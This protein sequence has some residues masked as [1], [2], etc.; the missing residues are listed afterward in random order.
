MATNVQ[1]P[2]VA[3]SAILVEVSIT[4]Y[5][6]K[7]KD[8]QTQ[9]EVVHD[10]GAGS[11]K[12]ASVYKNLFA[13]CKELDEIAKFSARVRTSHYKYTMP[14]SYTGPAL[15]PAGLLKE[16]QTIMS[17][18]EAEFWALVK[19]FLD[20][21]DT[22][23]AAA[24]FQLGS[25][26][27]RREYPSRSSI[28]SRFGFRVAYTPVPTSGDF[29]LDIEKEIQQDLVA[30]C[31]ARMREQ[32][33]TV[34]TDAWQR[35]HS[36]LSKLSDRLTVGPDGKKG[37]FH[38]TLVGNASELCGL[39]THLNVTGDQNLEAARLRLEDALFGISPDALR[40]EADTRALTKQKVDAMLSDFGQWMDFGDADDSEAV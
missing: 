12:A 11:R 28:A 35:L 33:G 34:M 26:F 1:I 9:E 17:Q 19:A 20:K 14:W 30:E 18:Y 39:L 31:E 21:Y 7:K 8:K 24:A 32:M 40:K 23:V 25:L 29:R 15:L 16:Y 36:V 13:E 10:K 2:A 6:G 27:D 5:T 37:R 3:R 38:D 4:S 22:L